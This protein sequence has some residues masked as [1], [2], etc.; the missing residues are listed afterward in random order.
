MTP[1]ESA[2]AANIQRRVV[3]KVEVGNRRRWRRDV[4]ES[5][6]EKGCRGTWGR[7]WSAQT[8]LSIASAKGH[9]RFGLAGKVAGAVIARNDSLE[10]LGDAEELEDP[11]RV[12]SDGAR[13]LQLV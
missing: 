12:L 4:R 7:E 1:T 3:D 13:Q 6:V 11:R 10:I 8:L 5:F 2:G 9:T